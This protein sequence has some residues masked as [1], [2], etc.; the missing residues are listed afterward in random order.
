MTAEAIIAALRERG[1][2]LRAEGDRLK[3]AAP[4]GVMTEEMRAA[5]SGCRDELLALLADAVKLCAICWRR[6]PEA[7]VEKQELPPRGGRSHGSAW[8]RCIGRDD[9]DAE[10]WRRLTVERQAMRRAG[11][12]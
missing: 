10:A 3:W 9:C 7:D 11:L 6:M 8:W 4:T 5:I 1:I 2:T 12:E